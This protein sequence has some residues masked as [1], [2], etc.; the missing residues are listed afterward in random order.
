MTVKLTSEIVFNLWREDIVQAARIDALSHFLYKHECVFLRELCC[1]CNWGTIE[2][3]AT[4]E[5]GKGAGGEQS[6]NLYSHR[7]ECYI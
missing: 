7:T 6:A 3:Q 2:R 1:L 4:M 5:A